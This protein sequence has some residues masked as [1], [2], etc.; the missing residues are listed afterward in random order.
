MLV[1]YSLEICLK[2]MLLIKHGAQNYSEKD[3]HHHRLVDLA[4]IVPGISDKDRA[5]LQA[6]THFTTWAGRYPDPGAK[7]ISS[8]QDVFT[9]AETH[10]ITASELF[11]LAGTIM[12]Y[13]KEVVG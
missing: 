5:I 8:A 7:R 11:Q 10:Q 3:H 4:E 13:S 9:L 6:L 12:A 2:A 1:G